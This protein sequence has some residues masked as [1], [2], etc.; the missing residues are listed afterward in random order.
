MKNRRLWA[1]VTRAAATVAVVAI[2]AMASVAAF[3]ALG[4]KDARAGEIPAHGKIFVLMVW[5]GLRPDLVDEVNT[6]NLFAL[7]REGV[8]FSRH[9]SI[10]PTLTMVDAAGLATGAGPGGSGIYGDMMYLAPVLDMSR[11]TAISGLGELLNDP[12]NLESSHYLAALNEPRAFDGRLL[13]LRTTAQEVEDGGGYVAVIGKQ[14]PTL[15]FDDDFAKAETGAGYAGN[16]MF[17]ADDMAAPQTM[18]AE[19]AHEPP[20]KRG[21]YAS[22]IARD[23]WFAKL[24]TNRALPAAKAASERGKPAFVVFWQHNPDLTQHLAGLGTRPA[25][26]AL[27]ACDANLASLRTAIAALGIADRTDLMVVSDH[28]FATIKA[29]VPLTRLLVAAGLKRSTTSKEIVV[30]PDGGSDSIYVSKSD[31]PTV[32]ARRGVL[33]RIVEYAAAQEW[34]GPMF[35]RDPGSGERHGRAHGYA[36]SIEG[37]FEESAFGM[38]NNARAPD[39]IISFRELSEVDNSALTGPSH[40]AF[41]IGPNGPEAQANHSAALVH[42]IPGAIYADADRFT[43]GMGM[44]GAAGA[45]ELHNFCAAI[46]PDFRGGLADT[47]P[48]GNADIAP[49]AAVILGEPAVAGITGRVLREALNGRGADPRLRAERVTASTAV[50]LKNS[51]VVTTLTLTRYAGHEY[52]DDAKVTSSR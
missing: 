17:V 23:A 22:A 20:M 34:S 27:R 24:A 36:G 37:T 14:G 33:R 48:T 6:P 25:L 11:A 41:S 28:G 15:L 26:N 44:H 29:M 12:L 2:A 51:R 10:Y 45:R 8:R 4:A 9:H 19:F 49:T 7:E 5:D 35:S 3:V 38:G 13:G 42:P 40:P 50:Q 39:L 43:S 30:A 16:F 46:G 21:D 47:A 1:V 31:F 32:E 52:F 18:L